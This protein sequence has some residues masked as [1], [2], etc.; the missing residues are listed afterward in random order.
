M[1]E[2]KTYT[3]DYHHHSQH[4]DNSPNEK[5]FVYVVGDKNTDVIAVPSEHSHRTGRSQSVQYVYLPSNKEETDVKYVDITVPHDAYKV[6]YSEGDR[7]HV[8]EPYM[9]KT[10]TMKRSHGSVIPVPMAGSYFS[11]SISIPVETEVEKDRYGHGYRIIRSASQDNL[12]KNRYWTTD[13]TFR[14]IK[15]YEKEK[16]S[17]SYI[18]YG[19]TNRK[20]LRKRSSRNENFKTTNKVPA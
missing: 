2:S 7:G 14:V 1:Y 6:E 16:G 9:V 17:S 20:C 4:T 13:N 3:K 18:R 8:H 10:S 19:C 15:G 5:Q 12:H 11:K